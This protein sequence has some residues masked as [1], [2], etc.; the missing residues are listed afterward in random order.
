MF[1]LIPTCRL[2]MS[3]TTI[4]IERSLL[5]LAA[6]WHSPEEHGILL[7][8]LGL[9]ERHGIHSGSFE[10]SALRPLLLSTGTSKTNGAGSIWKNLAK[11]QH[12]K[13]QL[14]LRHGP[15]TFCIMAKPTQV[16]QPR[17]VEFYMLVGYCIL[18]L[19]KWIISVWVDAFQYWENTSIWNIDVRIFTC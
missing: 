19:M 10:G 13:L 2:D 3:V 4:V 18:T 1:A 11:L 6:L 7:Q 15:A 5:A 8:I 17:Q 12:P 16:A 9:S 14:N